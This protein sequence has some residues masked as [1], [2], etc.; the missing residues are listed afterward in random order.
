MAKFLLDEHVSPVVAMMA[1]AAGLDVLAVAD[2][3]WSGTRDPGVFRLAADQ[4]RI[5]VTYN[6]QDF[7]PLLAE[8]ISAGKTSPGVVYVDE[9]T[10][11]PRD[12]SGLASALKALSRRIDSG[13]ADPSGGLFL[14]R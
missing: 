10:F 8:C 3:V 13:Q 7:A 4:G 14:T 5:V 12:F 9:R 11:D 1:R 2:S 6:I